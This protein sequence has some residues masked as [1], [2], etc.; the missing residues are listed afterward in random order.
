MSRGAAFA[1][2]GTRATTVDEPGLTDEIIK[3]KNL[4][5]SDKGNKE[6]RYKLMPT[7]QAETKDV[8]KLLVLFKGCTV[9][10]CAA[11]ELNKRWAAQPNLG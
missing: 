2:K 10:P 6:N 3:G 9:N 1:N 8:T 4:S 7:N 11:A 5:R